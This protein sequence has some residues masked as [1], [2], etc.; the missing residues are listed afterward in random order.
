ME[1]Q[2][3][4]NVFTTNNKIGKLEATVRLKEIEGK[5]I[6]FQNQIPFP[7]FEPQDRLILHLN[8]EWRKKRFSA[9]H[10][11]TMAKRDKT[12]ISETEHMAKGITKPNY[13]DNSWEVKVLP[14]PENLLTGKEEAGSAET[15]ENG[16]WYRKKFNLSQEWAGKTISLK[17][18]GLSYIG[19]IWINGSYIGYHEGGYTPFAFDVTPNITIGE[20]TIVIR[21]D[22][23]P[24]TTRYDIVPAQDNDFFNY[25][26]ILQDIF[27]E[28]TEGVHIVRADVVPKDN[29]GNIE[30]SVVLENRL[31]EQKHVNLIG[32]IFDTDFTSE[33][34]LNDPS[35]QSICQ[36][37]VSV[38]G[39]DSKRVLIS[40]KETR[41]IT[42]QVK[43]PDPKLWS[44]RTPN[45][46]VLKLE[47]NDNYE[48]IDQFHTQFGIRTVTTRGTNICLNEKPV[49][50]AGVAR[51]EEWP[52]SGRTASWEKLRND[53]NTIFNLSVN[54]VRT[55]HYPNH[56]YTYILLD[57]LG[58]T[59][60]VEIPLWQ[61]EKKH[62]E[63]QEIRGI[64]YQMWREMVFS[65]Y[66]R[67]SIILWS[68][69]NESKEV[70]LRKKYNE[71]LVRETKSLYPDG[72]LITQ[73]AAADQPGF[74]DE[75][76]EPLDV[77][78]WTMYFGIFHGSTP[79][80]GTRNFIENA[81]RA[82]PNKPII[83]TE[84][85]IWSN[86]DNS[87]L[88]KQVY[89]YNAVQ[90][91]LLEKATVAPRGYIN[92]NGFIAAIDYW[93][94]F[95]W[96]VNH[97]NFYQTMGMYHM[98]RI[99]SKPLYDHFVND[100]QRLL[101]QTNG[102][103][104]NKLE[105]HI[106]EL[107]FNFEKNNHGLDIILQDTVNFSNYNYLKIVVHDSKNTNGFLV[108]F[109]DSQ[110]QSLS[111]ESFEIRCGEPY[112]VYIPLWKLDQEKLKQVNLI[113]LIFYDENRKLSVKSLACQMSG[114]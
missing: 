13:D 112:S 101:D 63:A 33:N 108:Q 29:Q 15:Y 99:Q 31:N 55:A 41:V 68:T 79:Y 38:V 84:Y 6:P 53:F 50:L 22:N 9:D 2:T 64:S 43:I 80:E 14:S 21:V 3:K 86:A 87:F 34:W 44:I 32:K 23:P 59:A 110:N 39:L 69:Q 60:M 98:D 70:K 77:A 106:H 54:F 83:N 12:W 92:D 82:W 52:D 114:S 58:L 24:W 102:F 74:D 81:H 72:R 36:N 62:Y 95:D 26:G 113:S 57:R 51:H 7:S 88:E 17:C 61:F 73:S 94:V 25:T 107:S 4:S 109:K 56:I 76:M 37:E 27:L 103:G 85:G 67:P 78:G 93:T 42:Y 10:D 16:V 1:N 91:A 100:H 65:N 18:L 8:G 5:T 111:Y 30:I 97:N 105:N 20:N 48:I 46:Y 11:W 45:L 47:I 71:K 66:N 19:D 96:Y 90:S 40:A 104:I 35:A 75:S 89:I 49:F 28:G